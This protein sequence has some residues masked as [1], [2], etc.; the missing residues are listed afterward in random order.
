MRVAAARGLT[1][2]VDDERGAVV[3]MVAV[4]LI[5]LL[6]MLVLTFDL[7]RSVAIKRQMVN[8]TDAAAL[9]AAQE[10]ARGH[11]FELAR[12]AAADVL[13][14]NKDLATISGFS[15]RGCDALATPGAKVVTVSSSVPVQYYFAPIFG[16][17]S[18]AVTSTA[19]AVWGPIKR[20]RPI[21]VTVNHDQLGTC[22]IPTVPPPPGETRHCE[23]TYPKDTLAEPRWGVLDLTKWNDPDAAPCHIDADLLR[24][25]IEQGGWPVDLP[26]ND[27]APGQD[28]AFTPDCI[29]N[30]L[31]FSVWDSLVGKT[32]TF[33]VIDVPTSIGDGC[34][35]GDTGCQIDTANVI[36]FI[37]LRVTS[38]ENDGSTV[39]LEVEWSPIVRPSGP[40]GVGPAFGDNTIRLVK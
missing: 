1:R 18:G 36:D 3:A 11:G 21:P 22:S 7:G 6:G 23:L 19:T 15:A 24:S 40:V 33:P 30:G 4:S 37:T 26:I 20:S 9:A 17:D 12:A 29:D 10:C 34:T 35:G 2:L 5:V 31:S 14:D 27:P 28:I 32:V 38:A 8:G 13:D 16:V 25:E 39:V